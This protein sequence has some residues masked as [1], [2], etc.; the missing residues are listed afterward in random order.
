VDT[1]SG[2]VRRRIIE[3]SGGRLTPEDVQIVEATAG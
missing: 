1:I 2:R 3:G